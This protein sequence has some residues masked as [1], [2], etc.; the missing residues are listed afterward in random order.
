[1]RIATGR[2]QDGFRL[3]A[4]RQCD[5]SMALRCVHIV[6]AG[7]QCYSQLGREHVHARAGRPLKGDVVV[8]VAGGFATLRHFDLEGARRADH[9]KVAL[10]ECAKI[11]T[12]FDDCRFVAFRRLDAVE[13]TGLL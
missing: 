10:L 2:I 4:D 12:F 7:R 11:R 6:L 1:M 3:F 8:D 13:G 5:G 9:L